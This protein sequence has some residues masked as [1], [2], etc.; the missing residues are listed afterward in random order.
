MPELVFPLPER[1]MSSLAL[2]LPA[3]KLRWR[4]PEG[5]LPFADTREIAPSHTIVGQDAA[6]RAIAQGVAMERPGYNLFVSGLNSGGR[7]HTIERILRDLAPQRRRRRDFAYVRNLGDPSRP[8]LLELPAG[9]G[10]VLRKA[11]TELLN[12]L[13]DEIPRILDSEPVRQRRDQILREMEKAQRH[14]LIELQERVKE[15]GFAVGE[16]G[17]GED[18]S[19]T[20][21]LML[22][23]EPKT[24][25][26]VYLLAHEGKLDRPI[27]EIEAGFNLLEDHLARVISGARRLAMQATRD[28]GAEEKRAVL[29]ETSPLFADVGEKVKAARAWLRELHEA[30]GEQLDAFRDGRLSADE[31]PGRDGEPAPEILGA[32]HVNLLHRGG[33][34]RQ[35]PIVVV[36][37]PTFMNLFGG[38]AHDGAQGRPADHTHLRAGAL[39]DADGG[40]LVL[41][42]ADLLMESGSW[43]T[44]KRA[45]VFGELGLQNL[46]TAPGVVAVLRPDPIPLD[47]KV[48]LIGDDLTHA[49]LFNT[50]PDFPSIFKIKAEFDEDGELG[51]DTPLR[52]AAVLARINVR[53]KQRPLRRDAV[54]AI[55][56]WAVRE[57]GQSGHIRLAMGA[58]SDLAREAD[59]LA[60][61]P[62]VTREDVGR[63]LQF[64]AE[65]QGGAERRSREA[66][67]KD[68]IHVRTDG[69]VVGQV[70]GLAVYHAGGHDFGRPLRITATAGAGRGGVVS[71]ERQVGL[72]G[73]IHHKGVQVLS[74]FLLGRFGRTR[75]LALNA[76][77]SVEQHY[78]KIDGDS[79]SMAELCVLLSAVAT[80]PV[81][82]GRAVTGSVDQ[83]GLI[84]PIGG[85]N[86][87]IE[88]FFRL[89][90]ARGLTGEQGVI[91]PKQNAADLCLD[92]VVV[93][94][95]AAGLFHVW[96]VERVEEALA[97]LCDLP[98]GRADEAD[99]ATLFGRVCGALDQ[100]E[101][102]VRRSNRGPGRSD[103]PSPSSA[104]GTENRNTE[105]SPVEP[106]PVETNR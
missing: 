65:R 93:E 50:D 37:D 31:E 81:L 91:I 23:E 83:L 22:K 2:S 86:E 103:T 40:F 14:P 20:I 95:C 59:F 16:E 55:I 3:E 89:C 66:L 30:V 34:G 15:Q 32:F 6:L 96:A 36:P 27:E 67:I 33:R 17:E 46:E 98:A 64:R 75:T 79:A 42:A 76:S 56:E 102:V 77:L 7:L 63:A 5:G 26:E 4:V 21:V 38:I 88:G 52:I 35:A 12:L 57:G 87:K 1:G 24:R 51:P 39:H 92:E 43:K 58:L 97:L 72:S 47:V 53:E 54:A 44:L 8:Q 99:P 84:Q 90:A 100:L 71:I 48:V 49:I 69:A 74:G 106:S 68:L 61:G 78:G 60:A 105:Q 101:D 29:A 10:L 28:V 70:N 94:A 18:A 82:Q 11:V 25:P 19:P 85:V 104:P 9:A 62:L 80:V 13:F 45:M 73:R 41:H